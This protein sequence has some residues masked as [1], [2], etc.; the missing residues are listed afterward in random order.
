MNESALKQRSGWKNL[1]ENI[2]HGVFF[3]CALASILAVALI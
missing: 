2:M 3:V 1:R